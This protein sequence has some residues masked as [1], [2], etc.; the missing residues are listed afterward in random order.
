MVLLDVAF[1]PHFYWWHGW[2]FHLGNFDAISPRSLSAVFLFNL[3]GQVTSNFRRETN[4]MK[5]DGR[6]GLVGVYLRPGKKRRVDL[7]DAAACAT[8]KTFRQSGD[9]KSVV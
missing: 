8:T 1:L 9:R 7:L 2:H 5:S 3:R 6:K 4:L